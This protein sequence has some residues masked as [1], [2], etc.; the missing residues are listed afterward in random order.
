MRLNFKSFCQDERGA[1]FVEYVLIV[2]GLSVAVITL[3]SHAGEELKI[4]FDYMRDRK[5]TRL[6]S[7]HIP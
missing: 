7:S 5:S 2:A 3:I 4:M 6:N 1:S